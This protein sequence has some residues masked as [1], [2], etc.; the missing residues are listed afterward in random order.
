MFVTVPESI[1]VSV[2]TSFD[3]YR[4]ACNPAGAAGP[5]GPG[6][7]KLGAEYCDG[8]GGAYDAGG[9][10]PGRGFGRGGTGC[11]SGVTVAAGT[12]TAGYGGAMIGYSGLPSDATGT[13]TQPLMLAA[14]TQPKSIRPFELL[15]MIDSRL[16][17][18]APAG[19][20]DAAIGR[21]ADDLQV[22]Y[23]WAQVGS[24]GLRRISAGKPPIGTA[25]SHLWVRGW[26]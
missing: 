13:T 17:R 26:P 15:F 7:S 14:A 10:G 23:R 3:G 5:A 1:P 12:T 21:I 19:V 22:A 18:H 2:A 6:R 4:R 11:K 24:V 25:V 16:G 9:G 20:I 8:G